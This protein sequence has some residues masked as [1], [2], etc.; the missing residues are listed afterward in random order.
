M[1]SGK[2]VYCVTGMLVWKCTLFVGR[3]GLGRK[4]IGFGDVDVMVALLKKST[5]MEFTLDRSC[6]EIPIMEAECQRS[7]LDYQSMQRT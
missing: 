5:H 4:L 3:V 1:A 2:Q 7:R 6:T